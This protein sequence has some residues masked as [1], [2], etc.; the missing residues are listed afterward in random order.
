[1]A[2]ACASENWQMHTFQ[3]A[4]AHSKSLSARSDGSPGSASSETFLP[5]RQA[6]G[7]LGRPASVPELNLTV[8]A[9]AALEGHQDGD[10]SPNRAVDF[11]VAEQYHGSLST[12]SPAQV[13]SD[14]LAGLV[15]APTAVA[16]EALE[17]A[18]PPLRCPGAAAAQADGVPPCGLDEPI[19]LA[20]PGCTAED[21]GG[22]RDDELACSR[23]SWDQWRSS[24]G[25]LLQAWSPDACG[26]LGAMVGRVP[27][28]LPLGPAEEEHCLA[29]FGAEAASREAPPEPRHPTP[30]AAEDL[31]EV[32]RPH[33]ATPP[34]GDAPSGLF[35][36]LGFMEAPQQQ[37][38]TPPLGATEGA[39]SPPTAPFLGGGL[40]VGGHGGQLGRRPAPRWPEGQEGAAAGHGVWAGLPRH[41]GM[42]LPMAE[43]PLEWMADGGASGLVERPSSPD[44]RWR[45]RSPA[46]PCGTPEARRSAGGGGWSAGRLGCAE[47]VS[48][49]AQTDGTVGTGAQGASDQG[50]PSAAAGTFEA[51][52][53][54]SLNLSWLGAEPHAGMS[55]QFLGTA[56]ISTPLRDG[57][58]PSTGASSTPPRPHGC[59]PLSLSPGLDG[60]LQHFAGLSRGV[61][62]DP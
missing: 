38:V 23:P 20:A 21:R 49:L 41:A 58:T 17:A 12:P 1:M 2:S 61:L 19:A 11:G 18:G 47:V 31:A 24:P 53:V 33:L 29:S 36:R 37:S 30:P 42:S 13:L 60:P 32:L 40:D 6:F 28:A 48:T 39:P 46:S 22:S 50:L 14:A 54:P 9:E 26:G 59:Q 16:E 7:R 3:F 55:P 51:V 44:A 25:P 10:A 27:A 15:S 35:G 57:S 45:G 62:A 52:A 4:G 34:P 43:N 5:Q 8:V 56:K